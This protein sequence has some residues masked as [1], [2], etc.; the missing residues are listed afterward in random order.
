MGFIF[1]RRI[2]TISA[3]VIPILQIVAGVYFASQPYVWLQCFLEMFAYL[4]AVVL[5]GATIFELTRYL[6]PRC[7]SNEKAAKTRRVPEALEAVRAMFCFAGYACWAMYRSRTGQPIGL[8]WS[9]AEA[10]PEAP[11]NVLLYCGKM[12]LATLLV[13][14][15]MF[16]KHYVLHSKIFF[17]AFHSNHHAFKNPS[18][19]AG[20]AISPVESF[21]TFGP[22]LLVAVPSLPVWATAYVYWV[23]G[24][25]LLN[26][27]LHCGVEINIVEKILA[28]TFLNTSVFHNAH[29]EYQVTNFG[30]L[31]YLWDWILDSGFHRHP[32]S[33][34]RKTL[35]KL[36]KDH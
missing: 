18:A 12:V 19:F 30:E 4:C 25:V 1:S 22:S 29:H 10:Q 26:L 11:N 7:Q 31:L 2:G 9:L 5:G 24:F 16:A 20:F 14:G 17:T 13:D 34:G 33:Y 35:K 32:S 27:Y 23:T 3:V 36:E 6:G 15:Y 8:V 28:P 21:I